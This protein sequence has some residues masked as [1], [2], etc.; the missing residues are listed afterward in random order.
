[1]GQSSAFTGG[2]SPGVAVTTAIVG[3]DNGNLASTTDPKSIVSLTDRDLLG[4]AVT[5]I[6]AFSTGVSSANTDQ[7]TDYTYD[8]MD[9]TLSMTAVQS[10]G[11]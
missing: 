11:L 3:G 5:T 6:D 8:G 9:H 4:R 10:G 2:T 7:T 1:M